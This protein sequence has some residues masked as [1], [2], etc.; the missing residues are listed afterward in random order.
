MGRIVG[1]GAIAG[2]RRSFASAE[3][4]VYVVI[5][6]AISLG[7][8]ELVSVAGQNLDGADF[9]MRGILRIRRALQQ[10]VAAI[11]RDQRQRSLAYRRR[12]MAVEPELIQE[13]GQMISERLSLGEDR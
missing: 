8:D 6:V 5:A 12:P 11:V 13:P 2:T 1:L 7:G 4:G 9:R 3:P 10:G